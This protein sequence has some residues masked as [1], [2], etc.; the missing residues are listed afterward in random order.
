MYRKK[1]GL[2][3]VQYSLLF[4]VSTVLGSW[5]VLLM[6]NGG[7]LY[8]CDLGH[9]SEEGSGFTLLLGGSLHVQQAPCVHWQLESVIWK[10]R[11][12]S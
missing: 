2:C 8:L 4:Q 12:L 1:D 10:H 6:G 5:N 11:T 9:V 7:L 3:R